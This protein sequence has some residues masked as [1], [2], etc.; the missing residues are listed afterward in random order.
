MGDLFVKW[1]KDRGQDFDLLTDRELD[2][3]TAQYDPLKAQYA[4]DVIQKEIDE[5][6]SRMLSPTS[7]VTP[8]GLRYQHGDGTFTYHSREEIEHYQNSFR[9]DIEGAQQNIDLWQITLDAVDAEA[10][11]VVKDIAR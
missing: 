3:L 6:R 7:V 11:K 9:V 5:K 1:L 2:L 10:A 8:S 4:R